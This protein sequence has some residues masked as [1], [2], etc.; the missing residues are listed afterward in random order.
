MKIKAYAK[1]NLS[2]NLLP[3]KLKNGLY[4]VKFINCQIDL[5]DV[6][7]IKKGKNFPLE[8]DNLIHKAAELLGVGAE[9]K[10]Q[11]NIPISGGLAGGSSDGAETLKALI[12]LYKLKI[13]KKH[14]SDIANQL[15]KDVCYLVEGGL[16][17]VSG[18]GTKIKKLPYILPKLFLTIIYPKAVKPSTG[19]MYQNLDNKKIGKNLDKLKKIRLAVKNK[20][21]KEIIKNLFND[22]EEL[23]ITKFGELKIIKNDLKKNGADNS[24]LLGSGL[25]MAGFFENKKDRDQSF[26]KLKEKYT[27]IFKANT[28]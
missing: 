28:L 5:C 7:E 4:P 9:V 27:N 11:K 17:E 15:G 8:K 13:D 20:N 24:M 1:L 22:F 3:K 25:G 2:L 19:Y 21:K 10:L 6:L 18:D 16:C 23:A 14:L 26:D 12:K